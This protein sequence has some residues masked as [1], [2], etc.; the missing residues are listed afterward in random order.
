[1]KHARLRTYRAILQPAD[2]LEAKKLH[3]DSRG[4]ASHLLG[5]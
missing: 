1:V 3:D 2:P 4:T 5:K